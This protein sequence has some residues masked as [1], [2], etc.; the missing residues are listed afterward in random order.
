MSK[1]RRFLPRQI[2]PFEFLCFMLTMLAAGKSLEVGGKVGEAL[3]ISIYQV[4]VCVCGS[5]GSNLLK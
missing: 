1:R 5:V 3:F 2:T 4:C